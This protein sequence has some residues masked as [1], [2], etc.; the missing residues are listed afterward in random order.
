MMAII[1]IIGIGFIVS[2]TVGLWTLGSVIG[3]PLIGAGAYYAY[4]HL[5]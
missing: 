4:R 5:F 3:T 2:T 1:S